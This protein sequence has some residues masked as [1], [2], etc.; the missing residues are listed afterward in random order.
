MINNHP[1]NNHPDL[2]TPTLGDAKMTKT[3]LDV[4]KLT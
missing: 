2:E 1:P 4:K 3:V